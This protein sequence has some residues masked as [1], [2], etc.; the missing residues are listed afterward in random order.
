MQLLLI[1]SCLVFIIVAAAFG[2]GIAD[3]SKTA[4]Q[5]GDT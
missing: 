1:S 5:I 4:V 2:R 3:N